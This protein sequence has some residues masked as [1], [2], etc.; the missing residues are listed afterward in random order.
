[1]EG[2]A[3]GIMTSEPRPLAQKIGS[4]PMTVVAVVIR[5][6]RI[7]FKPASITASRI[8]RTDVNVRFLNALSRYVAITTLPPPPAKAPGKSL[9]TSA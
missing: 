9:K 5:Q 3:I 7:R 8:S 6:G 1:M 2:I 4:R